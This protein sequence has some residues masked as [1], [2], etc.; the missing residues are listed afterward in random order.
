V[1]NTKTNAG[2]QSKYDK[3]TSAWP[4]VEFNEED[5]GNLSASYSINPKPVHEFQANVLINQG[6]DRDKIRGAIT[7]SSQRES[8]STVFGISTPGRPVNDP[9]DDPTYVDRAKADKLKDS[10]I[11]IKARKG[12]HSFV[13]DDGDYKGDSQLIRLRTAGGHQILMSDSKYPG[14]LNNGQVLYI[15]NANGTAWIEFTEGGHINMYS[16]GGMNL[17]TEGEFNVHAKKDINFNSEAS[18][19]MNATTSI[20]TQT[21]TH[22]SKST[23]MT[24]H[25]GTM[26]LLSTGDFKVQGAT[27]SILSTGDIK[28]QGATGSYKTSG[29]LAF[30]GGKIY[31]NTVT[32]ADA[33]TVTAVTN[34]TVYK[35]SDTTIDSTKGI[36]VTKPNVFESVTTVAPSHEPWPRKTIK[37]KKLMDPPPAPV[38]KLTSDCKPQTIT[39]VYTQPV[40]PKGLTNEA[41]LE[42]YLKGVGITDNTK[43]AS[44]MGQCAHESGSWKY[45]KELGND[46]YFAKYEPGTSIGKRLGNTEPGDGPLYKGRGFIQITGR[47]NYTQAA[48]ATGLDLVNKPELAEDPANAC[49]LVDWFFFTLNKGRTNSLNWA[50]TQAVTRLV[51]GGLNGLDD[52]TARYNDYLKKYGAGAPTTAGVPVYVNNAG[53]P[54]AS[55]QTDPGPSSAIGKLVESPSPTS[56]MF[57]STVPSPSAISPGI[58]SGLLTKQVKALMVE[59]GYA[60]SGLDYTKNNTSLDRIGRYQINGQ[61]LKDYGYVTDAED[62]HNVDKWVGKD[63]ITNII[64]WLNNHAVQEKVMDQI[65]HDYYSELS[66]RRGITFGDDACMV[67]GMLSVAYFLRDNHGFFEGGPTTNAARWRT[68]GSQTNKQGT[69]AY[70]A[71]NQG[72]YAIDV[73]SIA[74]DEVI[75]SGTA[76]VTESSTV[77]DQSPSGVDPASVINFTNGSGD[78]AHYNMLSVSIRSAFEQMADEFKQKTGRK[79]MLSSAVRTLEEQ[80][81]IYNGWLAAGGSATNRTVNVPGYGN[82]SMPSKPNPNSPHVRGIA[83]DIGRLDLQQLVSF[84]LLDKYNFEFPFPVNDPVHIQFKG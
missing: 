41:L 79:I 18:I 46:A 47:Y 35:H 51:N 5:P 30:K 17:R 66:N 78:L 16:Q 64:D 25:T 54:T 71:Y 12:G 56:N 69:P 37:N 40:L 75:L 26:G 10:D 1:D 58:A 57:I 31:L 55:T 7:S 2:L 29:D 61:L 60:E 23:A 6:L 80:T 4:V 77:G 50:D 24:L 20:N 13:M 27:M 14:D 42:Q 76:T 32:P 19:H 43:L 15:S 63:G 74:E 45:V 73:L 21:A 65:L 72:R 38:E 62:I 82:I 3:A 28:I 34:L 22:T 39:K 83:Y 44:I 9:A 48:K 68:Q 81:K 33:P 53:T 84:G 52:R 59:I 11:N 67:A 70:V 8:P 36:Y 49:K